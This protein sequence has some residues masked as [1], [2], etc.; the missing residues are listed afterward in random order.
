MTIDRV[1]TGGEHIPIL[2]YHYPLTSTCPEK[3]KRAIAHG[4]DSVADETLI[5]QK[6]ATLFDG[7]DQ[8]REYCIGDVALN[9]WDDADPEAMEEQI[10]LAKQY[11][12]DGFI[13]DAYIGQ[14]S[15]EGVHEAHLPL[16]EAFLDTE[17]SRSMSFAVSAVLDGPRSVL[18]VERNRQAW[19]SGRAFDYSE[20]TAEAIVD[21]LARNYWER[22][23]YLTFNGKPYMSLWFSRF[24][25][26]NQDEHNTLSATQISEHIK[27]YAESAYGVTPYLAGV[28]LNASGA[29]HMQEGAFDA[30]TG[31]AFLPDFDKGADTIQNYA[32]CIDRRMAEWEEVQKL[33]G[34]PFVPPVVAGWDSSS[35]GK[36]RHGAIE[37]I[38]GVHPFGPIVT[39]V[40]TQE[41]YRFMREQRDYVNRSVPEGE[42]YTPICSWNEVTEGNAILPRVRNGVLDDSMLQTV[43]GFVDSL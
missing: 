2:A 29:A 22:E 27:S 9:T 1:S 24:V 26:F 7:H 38:D 13:F 6:S 39:D 30:L 11:G 40:N 41:F 37:D 17:G 12:L 18:P 10:G 5:V 3:V 23:N 21:M 14:R 4:A 28:C 16:D 25:S 43:Q 31:Y 32:A 33:S 42:R 20:G 35:R 36:L 34:L 8:P 19:E 15:G